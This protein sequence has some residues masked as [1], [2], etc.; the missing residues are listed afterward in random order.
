MATGTATQ[1]IKVSDA[2]RVALDHFNNGKLDQAYRLCSQLLTQRPKHAGGT[3]LMGMVEHKAGQLERAVQRLR[4]SIQLYDKK[5]E[6]FFHL[7]MALRDSGQPAEAAKAFRRCIALA[8]RFAHAYYHLGVQLFAAGQFLPAIKALK[9]T[10]VLQPEHAE[11]MASLGGALT[12]AGQHEQAIT[13]LKEAARRMPKSYNTHFWL[14]NAQW[15]AKHLEDAAI[16]YAAAMKLDDSAAELHHNLGVVRREQGYLANAVTSLKKAAELK[17]DYV[18]AHRSLAVVWKEL[19]ALDRALD[20]FER[21]Q[22]LHPDDPDTI[23][24]IAGTWILRGEYQRAW[25]MLTPLVDRNPPNVNVN[26]AYAGLSRRFRRRADAIHR[27]E[28]LLESGIY[29]SNTDAL[30]HIHFSLANLLDDAKRFDDAFVQ[31]VKAN[32]LKKVA[33][34]YDHAQFE[35]IFGAN[36]Q[37][38]SERGLANLARADND[39]QRPVFIVG[40]PRSGTSLVEQ[41]L[42][43]HPRVFGAGELGHITTFATTIANRRSTDERYPHVA[44][45]LTTTVLNQLADKYFGDLDARAPES[46]IRVTDKMPTNFL[47]LGMVAM[48]FP[49]ARIIHCVRDPLD[50]CLSCYFQ[51]FTG[52]H[53]YAYDPA[54]LGQFYGLYERYLEHWQQTLPNPF[55]TVKYED[56]VADPEENARRLVRFCGLRW[57]KK[58]LAFHETQ[59]DVITSSADQVRRPIYK[60]SVKRHR[61]YEKHVAPFRAALGLEEAPKPAVQ[62]RTRKKKSTT[63]LGTRKRKATRK[64]SD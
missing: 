54:T 24:A 62:G 15:R 30:I 64:K 7:G 49:K 50:T 3:H 35:T 42:S 38:F 33:R 63:V 31:Y 13:L 43:S 25:D 26:V 48:L 58:C 56:L 55:L 11:A 37:V 57:S 16:S 46:A 45:R 5:P 4:H 14:G 10:L 34:T 47:Y 51:N 32:D 19:G 41:M 36:K 22:Q 53:E 18:N 8:P 9:K 23:A 59:R 28:H 44:T 17:P 20:S 12:K 52:R 39:S 61:K 1:Q 27:L 6:W 21:A 40:M 29:R 60:T 2:L